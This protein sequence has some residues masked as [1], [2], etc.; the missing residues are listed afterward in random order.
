MVAGDLAAGG[1]AL[2][3]TMDGARKVV[4]GMRSEM[5]LRRATGDEMSWHADGG[6]VGSHAKPQSASLTLIFSVR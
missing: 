3:S 5:N 1:E 2:D 4:S 6:R